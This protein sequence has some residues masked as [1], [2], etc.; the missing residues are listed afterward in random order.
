MPPGRASWRPN[1]CAFAHRMRAWP[2]PALIGLAC[3]S[4]AARQPDQCQRAPQRQNLLSGGVDLDAR[5]HQPVV[6]D[7]S[8]DWLKISRKS[9]VAARPVVALR[10]SLG[11]AASA[12]R[13]RASS[14]ARHVGHR[15][16]VVCARA[17]PVRLRAQRRR[18]GGGRD[19]ARRG[20]GRRRVLPRCPG[21]LLQARRPVLRNLSKYSRPFVTASAKH[22]YKCTCTHIGRIQTSY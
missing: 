11:A 10:G 8:T 13:P 17:L 2:S 19:S 9:D 14:A 22:P 4:R 3:T 5:A 12:A 7:G 16:V 18:G 20:A 15:H 6:N 1:P 21:P